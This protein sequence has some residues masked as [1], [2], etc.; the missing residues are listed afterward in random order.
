MEIDGVSPPSLQEQEQQNSAKVQEKN[1]EF[2]ENTDAR[3][4]EKLQD[5]DNQALEKEQIRL[6]NLAENVGKKINKVA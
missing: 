2:A 5:Q 4:A 1:R 6:E 3:K